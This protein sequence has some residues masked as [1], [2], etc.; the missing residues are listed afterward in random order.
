MRQML[1]QHSQRTSMKTLSQC[2]LRGCCMNTS[3][4]R[5]DE[6]LATCTV[7]HGVSGHVW[8]SSTTHRLRMMRA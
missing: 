4:Y 7:L 3:T 5:D 8:T 2:C 6:K 1:R